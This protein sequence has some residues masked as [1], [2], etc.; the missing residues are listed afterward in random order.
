MAQNFKI[1]VQGTFVAP[2]LFLQCAPKTKFG[3]DVQD[4]TKNGLPKWEVHLLGMF[5]G[6]NGAP[7]PEVL[8]VGFVGKNPAL[9]L[10][11]NTQVVVDGLEVG[12]M[13]KT[14]KNPETGEE[15]IIGVTVWYR[16]ESMHPAF[17]QQA[18]VKTERA[19]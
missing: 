1:D 15:R 8:K 16:A 6:F 2:P 7:A 10:Q 17:T 4:V 5:A 14:K 3:S 19:A 11:A 13:E 9:E 12:V 18:P